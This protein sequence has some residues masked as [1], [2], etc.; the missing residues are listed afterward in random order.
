MLK[1]KVKNI[2]IK[3]LVDEEIPD[4]S[5]VPFVLV[6]QTDLKLRELMFSDK[7]SWKS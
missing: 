7:F 4:P 3:F 6:M 1:H 5:G 2:L